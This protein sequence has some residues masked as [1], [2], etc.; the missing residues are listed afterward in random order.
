MKRPFALGMAAIAAVWLGWRLASRKQVL[1]CPTWLG[2]IL[3]GPVPDLLFATEQTLDR[4]GLAPGQ[5]VLEAGPGPGRL[6][7][8]AARR[9]LPGGSVTGL[10]LQPGMA[11]R[12]TAR[13]RDAGTTNLAVV[14]GDARKPHFAP[15]SFDVV[16]LVTVL[17]EIPDGEGALAECYDALRPGGRLSITEIFPDPHFLARGSVTALARA[18]GFTLDDVD[19][20]WNFFT[21]NFSK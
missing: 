5:R 3:E 14:V 2:A 6:L 7:I 11:R 12:L 1:P 4:I 21:A 10:E 8:P 9:V 17:G 13:A 18:A 16:Y 15:E 19:G 20:G